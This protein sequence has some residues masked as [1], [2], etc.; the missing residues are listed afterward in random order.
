MGG[1][2]RRCIRVGGEEVKRHSIL[3]G[4]RVSLV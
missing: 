4:L 1:R 2:L 3:A